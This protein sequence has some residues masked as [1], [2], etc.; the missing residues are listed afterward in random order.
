[1]M[2]LELDNAFNSEVASKPAVLEAAKGAS[3]ILR[4]RPMIVKIGLA[5]LQ[6]TGDRQGAV[7]VLGPDG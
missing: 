7:T 1:M 4:S 6:L 3:K 2:P 5:C